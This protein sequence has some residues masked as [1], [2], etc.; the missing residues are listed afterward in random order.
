ML[1]AGHRWFAS[2]IQFYKRNQIECSIIPYLIK[3]ATLNSTFQVIAMTIDKYIAIKWPHKAATY[4]SP[5]R[6]KLIIAP[7]CILASVYNIPNIFW[8]KIIQSRC[9]PYSTESMFGKLHSW[10]SFVLE[11]IIPFTM[12]IYMNCIIVKEV[13]RSRK[14]FAKDKTGNKGQKSLT[15]QLTT[16]LLLVTTLFLI[17]HLPSNIRSIYQTFTKRDTPSKYASAMLLVEIA[18][19]LYTTNSGINFFLYCISGQKF[20]N[21]VKEILCCTGKRRQ[22]TKRCETGSPAT[23]LSAIS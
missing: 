16:M 23:K 6:A 7:L 14:K 21:D 17:L 2:V 4:S 11:A 15:N 3:T 18:F 22:T 9:V 13:R 8:V 20:R 19:E 12:L 10:L 1:L 5:E